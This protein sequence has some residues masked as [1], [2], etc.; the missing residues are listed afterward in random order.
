M[1]EQGIAISFQQV[2]APVFCSN[3]AL[4]VFICLLI[5]QLLTTKDA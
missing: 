2:I 5:S 3:F 1:L 4:F